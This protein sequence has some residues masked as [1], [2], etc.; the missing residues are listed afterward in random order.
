LLRCSTPTARCSDMSPSAVTARSSHTS[1]RKC[2]SLLIVLTNVADLGLSD[3]AAVQNLKKGLEEYYQLLI[4]RT[5][6]NYNL[7]YLNIEVDNL[8]KKFL[9][10]QLL[11]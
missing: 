9:C 3:E 4:E 11:K 8:I 7:S 5:P 6:R 2:L 10:C 1:M